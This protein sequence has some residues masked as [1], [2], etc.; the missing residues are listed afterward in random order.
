MVVKGIYSVMGNKNEMY[1]FNLR[2]QISNGKW[3]NDAFKKCK[4]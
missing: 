3:Q 4:P 1:H 2:Y